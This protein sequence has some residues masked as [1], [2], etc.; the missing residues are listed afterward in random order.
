MYEMVQSW[1]K[2]LVLRLGV[3]DAVAKFAQRSDNAHRR[4]RQQHSQTTVVAG[5]LGR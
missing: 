5:D 3:T 4:Q 1:K 2:I